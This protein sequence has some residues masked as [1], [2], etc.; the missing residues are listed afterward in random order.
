MDEL[1]AQGA[2]RPTAAEKRLVAVEP[3]LA[4]FA[5]PRLNSQQHR[6]PVP[7]ASSNTHAVEYS[8][9]ARREARGA[10]VMKI[11]TSYLLPL[12]SY[13]LPLTPYVSRF[14]V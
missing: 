13:L 12:T 14:M 7:T 4:D 10:E 1:V 9:G 3:F 11:L 6:L 8:E 5:I 2:P